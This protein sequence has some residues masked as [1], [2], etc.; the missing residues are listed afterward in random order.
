M[1]A[2]DQ[3]VNPS[4]TAPT[5]MKNAEVSMIPGEI[6]YMDVNDPTKTIRRL[7]DVD[8]N[9]GELEQK[10]SAI[11]SRISRTFFEDLFLMLASSDRRQITAREI[12][13]RHE[14]KLLALGPV[15]ERLNQDVLE[16]LIENT[17]Y[18]L[19]KQGR[20]PEPPESLQGKDLKIEYVSIMH[21]AQK[22]GSIS[23]I[24]RTVGFVQGLAQS[25]PNAMKKLNVNGV[26]D[27]YADVIGLKPEL[28][29]SDEILQQQMAQEQ[30]MQ[31]QAMQMEQQAADADAMQKMSQTPLG[32][33][34]AL[35]AM[36]E[37][38]M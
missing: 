5:S 30:A 4:M 21:Q 2:I 7:F 25:D 24:E 33:D 19:Q 29:V 23:H 26:I 17:F 37:D 1:Q 8:F 14:E 20:L 13:E 28:L 31:Q 6:T 27:E 34:S 36:I 3:K 22:I 32:N 12:D 10:Q 35:D 11:R 9:I 16:P 38:G 18:F 15:L